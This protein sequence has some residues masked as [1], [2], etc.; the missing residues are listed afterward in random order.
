[1]AE[2]EAF[3]QNEDLLCLKSVHMED[4]GGCGT[5]H[6]YGFYVLNFKDEKWMELTRDHVQWRFWF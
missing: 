6:L 2:D 1:M 5:I 4:L 3:V